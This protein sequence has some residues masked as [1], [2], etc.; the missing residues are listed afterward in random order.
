[1]VAVT[2]LK[3]ILRN[4]RG[5]LNR[6]LSI[7]FIVALGSG[8]MA[9]LA[10]ASPDMYDTADAYLRDCA[11]YDID[12]KSTLGFTDADVYAVADAGLCRSV[13]A[14]RLFDTEMLTE[15]GR[16][17]TARITALFYEGGKTVS[18]GVQLTQGR[19]PESTEECVI[20]IA[21]DRYVDDAPQLGS[22]LRL[23]D[24]AE[25]HAAVAE[26]ARAETLTVVGFCQSPACMSVIGEATTV[27][28]GSIG[29]YVYTMRDY[30]AAD[31][32]TDLYLSLKGTENLSTFSDAYH[33]EVE[34]AR[35]LLSALGEERAALRSDALR[36]DAQAQID[37][38]QAALALLEDTGAAVGALKLD[39]AQR[40]ETSAY[41]AGVLARTNPAL[42][43]LLA[44]TA[45]NIRDTLTGLSAEEADAMLPAWEA[46]LSEAQQTLDSLRDA[47]WFLRTRDDLAGVASYDGNVGKVAALS[48]VFPVFFF[49]VALL[50]ALT[51]MTRLIEE[52]RGE[53]GTLKALGF[54]DG[55]ILAEY[56][57]YALT[58]SVLGCLLGF[59]VGFRIFPMAI[60]AA[61]GMMY[62]LPKTQVPFRPSIALW[63]APITIASILLA[64]LWAC[65]SECRSVPAQLMLAKAPPA[66]KRI[67]LERVP[68]LWNRL[69]FT[70]KVTFRNLFRYKKRLFM[71]VIGVAGCSALLVTGFGMR[72][73]INDIVEKQYGEIYRYEIT[74]VM[75]GDGL[76]S[77][78]LAALLHSGEIDG[79]LTA[80]EEPAKVRFHGESSEVSVFV[81]DDN[82]T[83]T[84]FIALRSRRS[85]EALSL[86][87]GGIVLT[88]K[89]CEELGISVGDAVTLEREDGRSAEL[90]VTGVTENYITS[91]A[92][93]PSALY[94]EAFREDPEFSTLLCNITGDHA[95][96]E[97]E[98]L[99]RCAGV[100]FARSSQTL[101]DTFA[102]SIR[103][104]NGVVY[105]LILAAGLLSI[106]VLYNLTN[107][108]ICERR[109]E[110]ATLSVLGFH[111]RETERYIFRESNLLSFFGSLAGLA[112]GVWLHRFVVKTVEVDQVMFGR[113]IYLPSY[114]YA[115]LISVVFTLI[116][117]RIMSRTIRSID[118]VEAMKAND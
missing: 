106:V 104:M 57:G 112:V 58:A 30:L 3:N 103:S 95:R 90:P 109:K 23:S 35:E 96:E 93:V 116:V 46:R 62:T 26:C 66:G 87:D 25:N 63:V 70:R 2:R 113:Q 32:Y 74:A 91:F 71:T 110:L 28:S 107:V 40:L 15:E 31:Y 77:P 76:E 44:E 102:D 38:M 101:K 56:L 94:A 42:A 47:T 61:Y 67:L 89:L 59:A 86:T 50:V 49:L 29:L 1:M 54:S 99:M 37:R 5:S 34:S 72:D 118:M 85:G 45:E 10:A 17:Y 78:E 83:L 53:I 27:G 12:L 60:S 84:E 36:S 82:E 16:S 21:A 43:A 81:P 73:S 97:S 11:F 39:A 79:Y 114:I 8:F 9:G 33:D 13:E 117:N 19:L 20:Q 51:T 24:A 64:A 68:A 98:K 7:L 80:A 52:K 22:R 111:P 75:D 18:G 100:A 108:N 65:G 14:M 115:V 69:S 41:T 4:I 88:E 6:F 48:K 55:Q 92:Y 105:V